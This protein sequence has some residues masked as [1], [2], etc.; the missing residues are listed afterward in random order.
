M[1]VVRHLTTAA[2]A[3]LLAA[4]VVAPGSARAQSADADAAYAVV[5]RLFDA[6]RARDTAVMRGSFA[7]GAALQSVTPAGVQRAAI[8]DWIGSVA[9]AAE[10]LLLDERLGAPT[11]LEDG[12]LAT[13]WVPYW[14]FAG[15]RFSH[16]GVDAFVLAREGGTWKILSV[17]DTRQRDG[18]PPAP[19]R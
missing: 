15:E 13:V 16:C 18:C 14:F 6:M 9:R 12:G 17:A 11:V 3:A 1:S 8:D 10:G 2:R 19:E 5:T 7:A 4:F